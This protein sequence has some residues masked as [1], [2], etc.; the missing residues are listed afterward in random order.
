MNGERSGH[1]IRLA[2]LALLALWLLM[3][4][5]AHEPWADEAQAWSLARDSGLA[6]LMVE[7]V[8]YEGTPGLWHVMLW[9]AQRCGLTYSQLY[10]IPVTCALA[11]AAVVLWRAPFPLWVRLGTVC[12]YFFAYQFAVIA[13][14]YSVDLLLIPLAAWWFADRAERPLRYA[15]VIGLIANLNT[16]GLLIAA[17]LGFELLIQ[18]WRQAR[19]TAPASLLALGLAVVS[20]LIALATVW[21]P[22]DSAFLAAGTTP[23]WYRV[24][25]LYLGEAFVNRVS[26]FSRAQVTAVDWF[27]GILLTVYV[28]W[29]TALFLRTS[30]TRLLCL[31]LFAVLIGFT[32]VFA[33]PW[34]SGVLYLVWIFALWTG[35]RFADGAAHRAIML[36]FAVVAVAQA[37]QTIGT[38]LWDYRATYSPAQEVA[39]VIA[40]FDRQHPD[41][42]IAAYGYKSFAVQPWLLGNP[43]D[44]YHGGAARP[45]FVRWDAA[46]PWKIMHSEARWQALLAENPDLI[47]VSLT[48]FKGSSAPLL[49]AACKAGYV[50][51]KTF[52]GRMM[53]RNTVHE[54]DTLTLFERRGVTGTC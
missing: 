30:P 14:S 42:R 7:R 50:P 6:E 23:P 46:E 34:H 53:W 33:S 44:N 8:R 45:S 47:V 22:A 16:H 51:T 25:P 2:A 31:G 19:L 52:P 28:L 43:Y 40:Q 36:P 27:A 4:G 3:V 11:G 54:D 38:G 12:S 20:G 21:Q 48:A 39:A 15:L 41:A 24:L 13:R 9:I 17:L 5:A 1:A 35:W 26:I 37:V 18:L 29:R 32:A 49:P 10:L